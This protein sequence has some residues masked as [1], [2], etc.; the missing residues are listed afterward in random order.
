MVSLLREIGNV[1][2]TLLIPLYC[3]AVE[4]QSKQP[5]IQDIKAVEMMNYFS[6]HLDQNSSRMQKKLAQG[7]LPGLLQ[8][9]LA[10]R[11][12]CFDNYVKSF[13]R[14]HKDG[15]V[16]G[17]GCGLDARFE[18]LDNG[19][20]HWYDL[21]LA[22]VINVRRHFFED[23]ERYQM[24]AHSVLDID[25][26]NSLDKH[27]GKPFLFVAE[28]LFMYLHEED[29]K[30][31]LLSM[32]HNFPGCEL[33]FEIVNKRW[34]KLM[35]GKLIEKKLQRN[36]HVKDGVNFHF[37]ISMSHELENW[38]EGIEFVDDWSLFDDQERKI[39]LFNLFRNVDFFRYAQ[40]IVRYRLN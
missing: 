40:W 33:V 21:D 23:K 14:R 10:L 24:I 36:F 9:V 34:V 19:A 29:V 4:T 13:L 30:T 32:Q 3:R 5:I 16:V 17:L 35:H 1:S 26:F 15:V 7:K 25:W 18:R 12:R 27:R 11:T 38:N 31:L 6:K 8:V 22:E 39:G 28:G 37:G 2:E 20:I